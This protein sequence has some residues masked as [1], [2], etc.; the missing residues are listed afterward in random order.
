MKKNCCCF[1]SQHNTCQVLS[2]R[3]R[4]RSG[5][6]GSARIINNSN[7]SSNNINKNN[8]NTSNSS[9]SFFG[10]PCILYVWHILRALLF[11]LHIIR[12]TTNFIREA[13]WTWST[14]R[15]CSTAEERR[16]PCAASSAA[17]R[18]S[19]PTS[20]QAMGVRSTDITPSD[21]GGG[22]RQITSTSKYKRGVRGCLCVLVCVLVC[23][24]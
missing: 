12:I 20:P 21:E 4:F 6:E 18:R 7:S 24:Y 13:A 10:N 3:A 22:S 15:G 5:N 2:P 14:C 9:G 16:T 17:P 19:S 11:C 1:S 23:V 8:S